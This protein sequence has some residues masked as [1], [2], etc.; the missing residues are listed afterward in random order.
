[1]ADES[2]PDAKILAVPLDNTSKRY[3]HIQ[4][5]DDVPEQLMY[6]ISHFF[7]HYKDLEEDKWVKIEGWASV[8]DAKKEVTESIQR[9]KEAPV[10]PHF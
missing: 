6:Q 9:F 2:G 3:R 5:K 7:E 8:D 10:K 1:M 4:S